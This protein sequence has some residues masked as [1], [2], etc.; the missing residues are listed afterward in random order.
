MNP[1]CLDSAFINAE[2]KG[3]IDGLLVIRNGFIV[4]EDYYN[5]YNTLQ[6]HNVMSVSKSFL[7]AITGIA[8][9]K[10][11]LKSLDETIINYFPEDWIAL[12]LSAST[13]FT[14]PNAWGDFKNYN[15]AYLWWLCQIEDFDMYMGYGYAGSLS[16]FSLR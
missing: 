5:G 2:Q 12:S 9:Y 7:S 4:A 1:Q 3:F 8:L 13:N 14:H 6:S 11:Y 10:G 15:Y 16:S